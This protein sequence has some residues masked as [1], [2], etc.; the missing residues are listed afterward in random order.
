MY[1]KVIWSF[2][3]VVFFEIPKEYYGKLIHKINMINMI[4]L[5]EILLHELI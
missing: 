2:Q 4:Q 3:L 1:I 5:S